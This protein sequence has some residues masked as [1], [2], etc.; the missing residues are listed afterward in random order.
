[1]LALAAAAISLSLM[2]GKGGKPR[3]NPFERAARAVCGGHHAK[4][5][6]ID[7]ESHRMQ[8]AARDFVRSVCGGENARPTCLEAGERRDVVARLLSAHGFFLETSPQTA[9]GRGTE[10]PK[11]PGS[12]HH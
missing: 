9:R 11:R 6:C 8:I 4:A 12:L 1:M 7:L 10:R 5:K 2:L 3:P